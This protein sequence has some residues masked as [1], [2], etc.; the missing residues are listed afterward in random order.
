MD[1]ENS[2]K[3]EGIGTTQVDNLIL[4]NCLYVPDAGYNLISVSKLIKEGY[5]VTF[6]EHKAHVK[7]R[8]TNVSFIQSNNIYVLSQERAMISG[9]KDILHRRFAHLNC[10]MLKFMVDKNMVEGINGW[11]NLENNFCDVCHLAKMSRKQFKTKNIEEFE[12]LDIIHADLCGPLPRSLGDNKYF[13]L[14][15]DEKTRFRWIYFL[16]TKDQTYNLMIKFI[17]LVKNQFQKCFKFLRTDNGGEFISYASQSLLEQNGIIHERTVVYTPQQNGISERGNR[18]VVNM[19]RCMLVDSNLSYVFWAEA[20]Q[21]AIFIL[22]RSFTHVLKDK[23]PFE[24]LF[25]SKPNIQHLK[26][27]GSNC[28]FKVHDDIRKKLDPKG[29]FG[30]FLG[31]EGNS[32]FRVYDQEK[33]IVIRTRDIVVKEGDFTRRVNIDDQDVIV[34]KDTDNEDIEIYDGIDQVLL[35]VDGYPETYDE[36]LKEDTNWKEAIKKEYQSLKC[37]EY[38][39]L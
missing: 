16:K 12:K 14:L 4:K 13:L 10:K 18:I 34:V 35:T 33:S 6:E 32:I 30:I 31:Y 22:N 27:F 2:L 3:S 25:G 19:I 20:A 24:A 38:N 26:V 37:P 21:T 7:S 23:T 17:T 28:I 39:P 15:T 5:E 11:K 29:K 1:K 9:T 8:E 36:A